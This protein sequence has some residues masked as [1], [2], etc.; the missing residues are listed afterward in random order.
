MPAIVH[1]VAEAGIGD[2]DGQLKVMEF[3]P[4][5][6]PTRIAMRWWDADQLWIQARPRYSFSLRDAFGVDG[7]GGVDWGYFTGPEG[8]GFLSGKIGMSSAG[9]NP[10]AIWHVDSAFAAGLTFQERLAGVWWQYDTVAGGAVKHQLA[11]V[12][13]EMDIGDRISTVISTSAGDFVGAIIDAQP[14]IRAYRDSGWIDSA[15]QS[16]EKPIWTPHLYNRKVLPGFDTTKTLEHLLAQWRWVGD[17]T[18]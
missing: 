11:T 13:Y 8:G 4:A 14:G 6:G 10:V 9:W 15:R 1:S 17:P 2:Y 7:P 16:S 12:Y 5:G 18:A 3:G